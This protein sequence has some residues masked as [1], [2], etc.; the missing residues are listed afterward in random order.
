MLQSPGWAPEFDM[1]HLKKAEEYIS[2]NVFKYNHKKSED[3]S[4]NT[5]SD[6]KE[7]NYD[8]YGEIVDVLIW[9]LSP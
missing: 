1:K 2:Q 6:K 9:N 4:L 8:R 5:L 3:N 7:S